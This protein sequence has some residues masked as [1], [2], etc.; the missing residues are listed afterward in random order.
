MVFDEADAREL[1]AAND[2]TIQVFGPG[3]RYFQFYRDHGARIVP[4]FEVD[5]LDKRAHVK[6]SFGVQPTFPLP[7]ENGQQ[8]A[9]RT[10]KLSRSA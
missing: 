6:V 1:S 2:D 8:A 9:A 7:A 5:N 3:H 10:G 4:P